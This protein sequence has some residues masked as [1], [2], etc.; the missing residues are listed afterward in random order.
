M[1]TKGKVFWH[2]GWRVVAAHRHSKGLNM[3][4]RILL[5]HSD[6]DDFCF[7]EEK[8]ALDLTHQKP[9]DLP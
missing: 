8:P 6:D 5:F 9:R 4:M 1:A 3:S 2:C 7:E